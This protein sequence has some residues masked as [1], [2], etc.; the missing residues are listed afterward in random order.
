M[1]LE[2]KLVYIEKLVY[3]LK[4]IIPFQSII[5]I[6]YYIP[7][8]LYI[9]IRLFLYYFLK[10]FTGSWRKSYFYFDFTLS[11]AKQLLFIKEKGKTIIAFLLLATWYILIENCNNKETRGT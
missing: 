10:L 5:N 7:F 11:T 1:N 6:T 3:I 4:N 8:L 2:Y 9:V